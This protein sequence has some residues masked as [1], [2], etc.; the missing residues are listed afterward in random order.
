M[1]DSS[2]LTAE[3]PF[4]IA[5]LAVDV[6][7]KLESGREIGPIDIAYKT[8]GTLNAGKSNAILVCHALTGDQFCAGR[9]PV[10]GKPGWWPTMIG[11]GKPI[12]TDRY[13]V[14]CSN[15]L[16]GC[17]GSTGPHALDPVT[18]KPHG[19]NFPTLT[20]ADVTRAQALL[21]DHLGIAKL[22]AVVGGSMGGMNALQW[23]ASHPERVY[24][25]VII[26]A[27]ARHTA[28]NIAFNEVGRQAI[29]TDPDWRNGAHRAF[30]EYA[31]AGNTGY[32]YIAYAHGQVAIK[33]RH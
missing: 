27:T 21:I 9:N 1:P 17:M 26:A 3:A 8:Y 30:Q 18:G 31:H 24:S 15:I 33:L 10:T 28:Q 14:V 20:I 16:G 32:D 13:F 22:F 2:T 4:R 5:R 23:A 11:P 29:L 7:L 19:L 6:P 25:A 12:D